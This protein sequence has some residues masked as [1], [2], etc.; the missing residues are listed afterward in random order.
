LIA[1]LNQVSVVG[2]VVAIFPPKTFNG[3]RRGKIASL[4]VADKSHVMRVVLWNKMADMIEL[5]KIKIGEIIRFSHG[6][7]REDRAGKVEL[8]AGEKCEVQINPEDT[9]AKDFP[10]ISRFLT[11]IDKIAQV[12]GNTK[13]NVLGKAK[14]LSPVSDFLRK[15]S[16]SGRIMRLVLEDGTGQVP[17][18]I[19][20]EN[21]LLLERTLKE[22]FRLKLVNAKVKRTSARGS[23]IHVNSD[24][25]VEAIP[26]IGKISRI[27]DLKDGSD[28]VDVEGE[29]VAKPVIRQVKTSRGEVVKLAVFELMD[30]TGVIWVSAWRKHAET[31]GNLKAGERI[32]LEDVYVR[33][34]FQEQLELSTRNATS[35]AVLC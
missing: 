4:L 15:D 30:G 11:R 26:P 29:V 10:T 2:R 9:E 33:K 6:Y 14:R 27:G 16:S 1:G 12:K 13:V 32:R 34:G 22:G 17:V 28:Q 18:V 19:W 21:A 3:K 8:H 25:Y 5:G 35:I 31:V 23:E 7:T 20:N 24:T